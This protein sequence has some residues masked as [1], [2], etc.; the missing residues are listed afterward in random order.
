MEKTI[1]WPIVHH[2]GVVYLKL[3]MNFIAE[4]TPRSTRK[5]ITKV[6]DLSVWDY[7]GENARQVCST[8]K[9]AYEVLLNKNAVLPDFLE[10]IFDILERFSVE[11]F[12]LHIQGI[13][14][15]HNQ[16]LKVVDLTYL[17]TEAEN[18]YQEIAD[19]NGEKVES[20]F[21]FNDGFW[22][23]GAPNHYVRDCPHP[24]RIGENNSGRGGRGRGR[25]GRGL[26]QRCGRANSRC[27]NNDGNKTL[28]S[29]LKPLQKDEE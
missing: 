7:D 3:I 24:D 9:G 10:I 28:D 14:T 15:N 17:L 23:C 6:Q 22:N 29:R 1:G 16:C 4:S 12:V 8:I 26:G 13:K 25:G 20:G 19:W 2:T 5:L 27:N 21:N 11:K 18:K